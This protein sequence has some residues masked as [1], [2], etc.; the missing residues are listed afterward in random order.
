MLI[1]PGGTREDSSAAVVAVGR[2]SGSATVAVVAAV[3]VG[4]ETG[5]GAVAVVVVVVDSG[6]ESGFVEAGESGFAYGGGD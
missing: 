1:V 2:G 4:C 3:V 5:Y 6:S